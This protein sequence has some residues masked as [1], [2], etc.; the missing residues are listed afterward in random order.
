M[1]TPIEK[2]QFLG[3]IKKELSSKGI[4]LDAIDSV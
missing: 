4:S 1:F 3:K 2:R